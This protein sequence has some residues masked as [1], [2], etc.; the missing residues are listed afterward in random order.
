LILRRKTPSG[1]RNSTARGEIGAGSQHCVPTFFT[2]LTSV[3]PP[4]IHTSPTQYPRATSTCLRCP[5]PANVS[6]CQLIVG[7]DQRHVCGMAPFACI[8]TEAFR[9]AHTTPIKRVLAFPQY[10]YQTSGLLD[11][12]DAWLPPPSLDDNAKGARPLRSALVGHGRAT[13][14]RCDYSGMVGCWLR[15]WFGA[16]DL[17]M[18]GAHRIPPRVRSWSGKAASS[19]ATHTPSSANNCRCTLSHDLRTTC[20]LRRFQQHAL[21]VVPTHACGELGLRPAV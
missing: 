7:G 6:T 8:A 15:C 11:R 4:P 2:S 16:T 17:G 21:E 10:P 13:R 9:D 20:T 12:C 3:R 5:I 19:H 1:D 18:Q 14:A